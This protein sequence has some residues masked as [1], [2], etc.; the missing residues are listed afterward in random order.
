M[1]VSDTGIR[2][3]NDRIARRNVIVLILAQA[4]PGAQ[5]PM[6]FTVGGLAGQQIAGNA[7]FATL[8]I[9][10]I[11]FGSMTTAPWLSWFMQ[12]CGRRAGFCLGAAAGAIG[13]GIAACGLY[14]QSFALLLCGSYFTGIYMSAHGF[15]RFAAT[16]M[17]TDGFRARAISYTMAG[18][19]LGAVI[20]A[21]LIRVTDT[22]F[23]VPFLGIYGAI[24]LLNLSGFVLFA[25][26]K[27][28][29]PR[30]AV[31]AGGGR[32]RFELLLTHRIAVAM[33]CAM[34]SYA[35]MNLVMTSTPLA[36]VGCGFSQNQAADI[37]MFHV[38]AMYAPGFFTGH[39]ISRF[40]AECIVALG[41]LILAVAGAVALS[42]VELTNFTAALILLGLG[43][44]F[45]F[46]G[47]TAM[48]ANSHTP[49]ERGHLQG[50]N[51][52]AVFGLVTI[53]SLSSGGLMNC[54][55]GDAADGWATVNLAMVPF[56]A[57]AFTSLVWLN[58]KRRTTD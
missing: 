55:G 15:Y 4:L 25:F 20:G 45:G 21:Q 30:K 56:L 38:L 54:F 49:A 51:D 18:G 22:T 33:I 8:P 50:M 57:L 37:V 47:S 2:S 19:L 48:L 36:V 41:L 23:V 52:C 53:A 13:A 43:W 5:L 35:L 14:L 7:C 1:T 12:R 44:N 28:P 29:R 9:S 11:V 42:G 16:D 39:L 24:I 27:I 58:F 26:L 34:V 40:G 31:A 3:P 17:A 10:M 6:I 32:S 46:I